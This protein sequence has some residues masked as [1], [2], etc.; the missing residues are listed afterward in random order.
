[1][2]EDSPVVVPIF[3]LPNVVLFPRAVLPLH[4]F[5]ERYRA[6]TAAALRGDG[7]IAMALLRP[8]WESSG[9]M[10]DVGN[11][12]PP[13]VFPTVCVG[14]IR[15][16]E[17]LD[18]GR[19]N[20]LLEGEMR[21]T[22]GRELDADD[23]PTDPPPFRLAALTPLA[24]RPAMDIDLGDRREQLKKVC[25]RSELAKTP[26]GEQ[27]AKLVAGPIPT[28]DLADV[29]AFHVLEDVALK[30][31]LL[32]EADVRRRVGRTCEALAEAFPVGPTIPPSVSGRFGLN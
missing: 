8:G 32:E 9:G 17:H 3:P 10:G 22:I 16:H 6:M 24:E 13:A 15:H 11:G 20:L 30:Q 23:F 4:I 29:L 2:S 14:T 31:S 21:A 5:E 7:R 26:V 19:Y 28:A 18:D 25:T 1:M 12:A 27:L